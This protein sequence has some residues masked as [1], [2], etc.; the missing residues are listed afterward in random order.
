MKL[1]QVR[2]RSPTFTA[3]ARVA[4]VAVAVI[5]MS[6]MSVCNNSVCG[7]V[8]SVADH[9]SPSIMTPRSHHRSI[10]A[11]TPVFIPHDIIRQP[12]LVAL[13]TRLKMTPAQQVPS[14][15]WLTVVVG[16]SLE[17]KL[18]GVSFYKNGTDC[19]SG[20]INADLTVDLL[21]SWNCKDSIVNV[22]F[23]TTAS[24]NNHRSSV[25][26]WNY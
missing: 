5:M 3:E 8:V 6:V 19:K 17:L 4:A 1:R 20:Y 24:N 10:Q 18:L 25:S 16:N 22:T 23:D 15:L 13:A 14:K 7:S 26:N 12:K 21:S 2:R 9:D 11:G